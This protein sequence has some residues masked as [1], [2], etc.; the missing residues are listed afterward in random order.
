MGNNGVEG[1][2]ARHRRCRT[3]RHACG[4]PYQRK[5]AIEHLVIAEGIHELRERKNPLLASLDQRAERAPRAPEEFGR[6]PAKALK[7]GANARRRK[8]R[9]GAGKYDAVAV[10]VG[11]ER[12]RQA[13]AGRVEL[14]SR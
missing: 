7:P 9:G 10:G 13:V 4:V 14:L 12:A 6:T 8:A 5:A 2:P 3:D 11:A 1:M